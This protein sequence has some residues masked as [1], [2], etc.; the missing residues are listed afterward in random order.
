MLSYDVFARVAGED[1][2]NTKRRL[3]GRRI[4][5]KFTRSTMYVDRTSRRFPG[6]LP[7]DLKVVFHLLPRFR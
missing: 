7:E 4:E 1:L 6:R 3:G 5:K 2:G